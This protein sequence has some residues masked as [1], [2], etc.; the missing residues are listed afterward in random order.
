[1]AGIDDDDITS[2]W[3]WFT[4]AI[5]FVARCTNA[6]CDTA[7]EFLLAKLSKRQIRYRNDHLD[8][9]R[10][11]L[12]FPEEYFF[13]RTP[14]VDHEVDPD[15]TV[16]RIGPAIIRA[17]SDGELK[18]KHAG[19]KDWVLV[20]PAHAGREEG[21]R[22][23]PNRKVTTRMPLVRLCME[24]IVRCLRVAGYVLPSNDP[25]QTE[26]PLSPPPVSSSSQATPSETS[27]AMPVLS[28]WDPRSDWTIEL[29]EQ[30]L[31]IRVREAMRKVI[32]A[33][34][35]YARRKGKSVPEI[36]DNKKPGELHHALKCGSPETCKR[37]LTAWKNWRQDH[38]V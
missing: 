32:G 21:W 25:A 24:D 9:G 38:P 18:A 16:I 36:L 14:A 30:N 10:D 33:L 26:L 11:G 2:G 1:M 29:V 23:D 6:P 27:P 28:D 31:E 13:L 19:E 20:K 3:P 22:F 7:R 37:L 8:F 4:S 17:R 12:A 15:N 5:E 35:A 34:P